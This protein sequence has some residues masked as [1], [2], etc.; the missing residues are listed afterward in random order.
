MSQVL[1]FVMA[2]ESSGIGG[3]FSKFQLER[4]DNWFFIKSVGE[5]GD[6]CFQIKEVF[7]RKMFDE[8][9]RSVAHE[10]KRGDAGWA[11][12]FSKA[13]EV[14]RLVCKGRRA[15]I[16]NTSQDNRYYLDRIHD[17]MYIVNR[18]YVIAVGPTYQVCP[19]ISTY[20]AIAYLVEQGIVVPSGADLHVFTKCGK[21][22]LRFGEQYV[23]TDHT[24]KEFNAVHEG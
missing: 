16:A 19:S 1:A 21:V 10:H 14:L 11:A 9:P 18:S 2:F 4:Q 5:H 22:V 7:N 15:E 8:I 6:Y 3:R 13:K 24:P 12:Y 23:Y 20:D 17:V